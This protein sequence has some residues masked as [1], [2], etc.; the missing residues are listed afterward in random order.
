MKER[1]E[2]MVVMSD[3]IE[4]QRWLADH[5]TGY[6]DPIP[7]SEI[8]N[9]PPVAVPVVITHPR[10]GRKSLFF[11]QNACNADRSPNPELSGLLSSLIEEAT[12]NPHNRVAIPWAPNQIVFW[13]NRTMFHSA[14][15]YD[16]E[17]QRRVFHQMTGRG[18][19]IPLPDAH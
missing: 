15:E 18:P 13:N 10:T 5:S 4:S 19:A 1:L 9:Y 12:S 2:G 3:F 11:N 8:P 16:A 17:G 7:D 14:P 6:M